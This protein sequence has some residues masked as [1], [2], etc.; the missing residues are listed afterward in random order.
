M[1]IAFLLCLML[2]CA[3][4]AESITYSAAFTERLVVPTLPAFDPSLGV[5]TAVDL[6]VSGEADGFWFTD[7]TPI[8]S[9]TFHILFQA[10]LGGDYVGASVSSDPFTVPPCSQLPWGGSFLMSSTLTSNLD[11]FEAPEIALVFPCSAWF[12]AACPLN[13]SLTR[14]TGTEAITYTFGP[15]VPEP[16][17][18]LLMGLGIALVVLLERFVICRSAIGEILE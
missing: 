10:L 4:C 11:R 5:L 3:A 15:A 13:G 1:K 18:L 7:G 8:D 2:P 14:V 9:G 17:S 6:A 16:A 12:D